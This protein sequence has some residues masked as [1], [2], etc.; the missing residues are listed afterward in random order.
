[1][2]A[3]PVSAP[4]EIWIVPWPWEAPL[5]WLVAVGMG[6]LISVL[7]WTI[8]STIT[9]RYEPSRHR[10]RFLAFM[11][12]FI[13]CI[14][15]VALQMTLLKA[16]LDERL[17][18]WVG[19]VSDLCSRSDFILAWKTWDQSD[20]LIERPILSIGILALPCLLVAYMQLKRMTRKQNEHIARIGRRLAG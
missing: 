15:A 9:E 19:Q 5:N 7:A 18:A 1:M 4:P 17:Y 14:L 10:T 2:P 3:C 11:G 12:V 16:P 20:L 6:A 8:Y 13:I